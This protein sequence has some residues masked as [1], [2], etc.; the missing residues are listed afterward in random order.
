MSTIITDTVKWFNSDIRCD[1]L[2]YGDKY[3]RIK[4]DKAWAKI[5]GD[6]H[7]KYLPIK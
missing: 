4:L 5:H 2:L 1:W 7:G 3:S 6:Y